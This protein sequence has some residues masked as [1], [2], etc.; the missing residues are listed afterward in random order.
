MDV[1]KIPDE[2]FHSDIVELNKD[3]LKNSDVVSNQLDMANN[4]GSE[5]PNQASSATSK[6]DMLCKHSD[7]CHVLSTDTVD[8]S[9]TDMGN[10]NV[11]PYEMYISHNGPSV[12]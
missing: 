10:C 4:K 7:H 2:V 8:S 6:S 9:T 11:I 1:P 12:Y 5:V 3:D